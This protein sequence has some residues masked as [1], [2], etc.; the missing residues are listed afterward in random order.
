MTRMK[1]K[2]TQ[3]M[4][5]HL[6][7]RKVSYNLGTVII[8][9][10]FVLHYSLRFLKIINDELNGRILYYIICAGLFL[11][12]SSNIKLEKEFKYYISGYAALLFLYMFIIYMG[13][14]IMDNWWYTKSIYI[15]I[16]TLVI[17]LLWTFYRH[18][19]SRK[20]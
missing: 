13:D 16:G 15:I 6:N 7:P 4:L 17:C 3:R 5:I 20:L 9:I 11:V 12:Y 1:Q 19:K 18:L 2:M 8:I 10:G 14:F